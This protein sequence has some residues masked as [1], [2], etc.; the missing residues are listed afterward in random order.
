MS[1]NTMI[2]EREVVETAAVENEQPMP[3][4]AFSETQEQALQT[5]EPEVTPYTEDELAALKAQSE[6]EENL[7]PE[8]FTTDRMDDVR[9]GRLTED[10][11][12]D[13]MGMSYAD[14]LAELG[15]APEGSGAPFETGEPGPGHNQPPADATANEVA[16][17]LKAYKPK[18]ATNT[19]EA[20]ERVKEAML[21]TVEY[22]STGETS[23]ASKGAIAIAD[24]VA[25]NAGLIS[26]GNKLITVNSGMYKQILDNLSG[27]VDSEDAADTSFKTRVGQMIQRAILLMD[28]KI[29][30]GYFVL[31]GDR[32][33][34]RLSDEALA[35][36]PN[37]V[38]EGARVVRSTVICEGLLMP[39]IPFQHP[40]TKEII[41]DKATPN[42][43]AKALRLVTNE[44]ADALYKSLWDKDGELTYHP[45]KGTII[46]FKSGEQVRKEIAAA[47][48]AKAKAEA[49]KNAPKEPEKRQTRGTQAEGNN[50][51][52]QN[53]AL[54]ARVQQAEQDA[55]AAV[56]SNKGD[57]VANLAAFGAYI[58][59][60]SQPLPPEARVEFWRDASA[61]FARRLIGPN[62]KPSKDEMRELVKLMTNLDNHLKWNDDKG[63]WLFYNVDGHIV[64]EF[65]AEDADK[66]A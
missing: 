36:Y 46:G 11:F 55:R 61:L 32:K 19:A 39:M 29:S 6:D 25:F 48:A 50:L 38:P 1:D 52:E 51:E 56:A 64:T 9:R 31:P 66:A 40:A 42:Q 12:T 5:V 45:I 22:I 24:W 28:N 14:C 10:Q 35:Q 18:D 2:A 13:L 59:D 37:E 47:E 20:Q 53:E 34:A 23:L 30:V 21:A 15:E 57:I 17:E 44:V 65:G 3:E 8:Q 63:I 62:V 43:D 16:E 7:D 49:E 4:Q 41:K 58:R 54:K 27:M 26:N 33:S 60:T